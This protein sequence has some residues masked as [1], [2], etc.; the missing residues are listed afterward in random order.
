MKTKKI[1]VSN[2]INYTYFE[3]GVVKLNE[4][5]KEKFGDIKELDRILLEYLNRMK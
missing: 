5:G 4:R 3:D 1:Q 2:I